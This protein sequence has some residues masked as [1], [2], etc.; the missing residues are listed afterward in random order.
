MVLQLG[1]VRLVQATH[2]QCSHSHTVYLLSVHTAAR[3]GLV[4]DHTQS[5]AT[6]HTGY[7]PLVHTAKL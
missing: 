1:L 6:P 4:K 5:A 7:L 3:A 2:T